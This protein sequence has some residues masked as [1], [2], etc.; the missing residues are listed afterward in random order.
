MTFKKSFDVT[1]GAVAV[2]LGN[3]IRVDKAK[4]AV[5][6]HQTAYVDEL[7][8]KYHMLDCNPVQTP[9]INRLSE[10]SAGAKLSADDHALYR[11]MVGS[12]LYLSCW[13][14]PDIAF[15]VSE[16]SRFVSAPSQSH[17]DAAKHLLRYLK[18]TRSLVLRYSKLAHGPS[19]APPCGATSILTGQVV[20]ILAVLLRDMS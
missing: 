15:A 5:E 14:R 10:K 16:L 12:L 11:N 13:S 9:I 8:E 18:G 1:V 6:V 4:L 17:L 2:Y 19:T 7:L 3:H 20:R